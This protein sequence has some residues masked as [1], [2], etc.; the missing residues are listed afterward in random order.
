[1]DEESAEEEEAGDEPT[2]IGLVRMATKGLDYI[3]VQSKVVPFSDRQFNPQL[4]IPKAPNKRL[5]VLRT[6]EE[7]RVEQMDL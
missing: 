3:P 7:V 4:V 2:K 6:K 5:E 1:M